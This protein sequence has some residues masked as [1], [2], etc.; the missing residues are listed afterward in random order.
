MKTTLKIAAASSTILLFFLFT[1]DPRSI[2]SVLLVV[3]FVL[4]FIVIASAIP[5]VFG[6]QQLAKV[7]MT[8]VGVTV[9]TVSVLLLGLQSLGQLTA[10]DVLAVTVLFGIAYF[11]ASR[12]GMRFTN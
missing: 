10:R 6:M 1:T 11:Y 5:L 7:K 4:L 12:M 9:A 2:P 3:P 8:K